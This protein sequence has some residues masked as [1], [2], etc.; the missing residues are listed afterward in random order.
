[1]GATKNIIKGV[2]STGIYAVFVIVIPYYSITSLYNLDLSSY[3]A[4]LGITYL[5]YKKTVFYTFA[6]GLLLCGSAFF[7]YSSPPK[8]VRKAGIGIL[9]VV[10]NTIYMWIYAYSG[11]TA[12]PIQILGL[13]EFILDLTGMVLTSMVLYSL[14]IIVK[15]YDVVDFTIN[16]EKIQAEK[17]M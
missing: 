17:M 13:G 10:L 1:M 6:I 7:Y 2:I 3:G 14:T 9:Q 8:S 4:V 15:I 11:L 12:I 16:K 5:R